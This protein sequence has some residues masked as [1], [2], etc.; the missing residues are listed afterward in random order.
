MNIAI[1]NVAI[2]N[3]A[4]LKRIPPPF[5]TFP[6]IH[7]FWRCHPSLNDNFPSDFNIGHTD[8]LHCVQLLSNVLYICTVL[9]LLYDLGNTVGWVSMTSFHCCCPLIWSLGAD[10]GDDAICL[11]QT[12]LLGPSRGQRDAWWEPS[13][14]RLVWSILTRLFAF[15]EPIIWSSAVFTMCSLLITHPGQHAAVQRIHW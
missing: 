2:L 7:P 8:F 9:K 13:V 6:K 1:L 5:G 3:I 11:N 15:N 12:S 10:G 4:S 14:T